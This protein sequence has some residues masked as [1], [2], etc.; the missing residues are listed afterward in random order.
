M[1]LCALALF[2]MIYSRLHICI[3]KV[4]LDYGK[5]WDEEWQ[6]HFDNW[7]P[8]SDEDYTPIVEMQKLED[9]R[10]VDELV[11]NPYPSNVMTACHYWLE[12]DEAYEEDVEY[13][14]DPDYWSS[15]GTEICQAV[16]KNQINR[17]DYWPCDVISREMGEDGTDVYTVQI[18]QNKAEGFDQTVWHVKGFPRYLTNYKKEAIMFVT[19]KYSSD[20]HLAG[21]FRSP[22]SIPDAMLPE[23]WRDLN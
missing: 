19:N 1:I 12:T 23:K 18:L 8:P 2:V 11:D 7:E 21:T 9:F 16:E 6:K 22:L 14:N 15:D 3:T 17:L 4:F 20:Q 5:P 10:T 13:D